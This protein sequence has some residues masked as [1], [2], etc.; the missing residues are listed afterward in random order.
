[1]RGV[2][3][4]FSAFPIG[5]GIIPAY[6]GSTLIPPGTEDRSKDHPRLCGEYFFV[7]KWKCR[8]PGSSPPMR[9]VLNHI[10][11][12]FYC[13]GIIPAYA[14]STSASSIKSCPIQD[15][16]RLCGEYKAIVAEAQGGGGSS[17]PMRGVPYTLLGKLKRM[18]IIPAY[19][20][21]TSL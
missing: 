11:S 16:P 15:H 19:A 17:P 9:G 10:P 3:L 5:S 4:V 8:K 21:S 1:M 2:H 20:G 12:L 6:A 7:E 14:G 18:R 13:F